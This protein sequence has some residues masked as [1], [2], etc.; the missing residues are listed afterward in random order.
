[1]NLTADEDEYDKLLLAAKRI[2]RTTR[3]DF[4]ISLVGDDFSRA[5]SAYVGK[6]RSNFMG[7]KFTIYDIQP[8]NEGAV[9]HISRKS[10]RFNA[11]QVSPRFPA[12]NYRVATICYKLHGLRPKRPR[13][14]HCVMLSIPA[15]SVQEGGNVP[16]PKSFSQWA[17]EKPPSLQITKG[18]EPAAY[19]E[20]TLVLKNR[21][22]RWHDEMQCWCLNFRGRVTVPSV[23]N[24]QLVTEDDP[25][26]GI[27]AAEHEKIILQFGK[28]A[29]DIFTM[30]Y[31]YP[32]SALQAFAICL[33][34]FDSKPNGL[35]PFYSFAP[36]IICFRSWIA[37]LKNRTK[38]NHD[39]ST[40]INYSN[41]NNLITAIRE[42]DVK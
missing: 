2:K 11:K 19:F 20:E 3:T 34:S 7:D 32:L 22:P 40:P 36:L 10:R 8:P 4:V 26:P 18:I 37:I 1:M 21:A 41:L 17:D 28:I 14:M 6:L 13:Q 12:Y 5:S 15:S 24:F 23:K 30:D 42:T 39:P 16:T 25:L 31:R 29:E 35:L 33:S 38:L 9:K 27:P